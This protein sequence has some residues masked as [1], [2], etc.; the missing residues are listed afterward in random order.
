MCR[1]SIRKTQRLTKLVYTFRACYGRFSPRTR[2]FRCWSVAV[3]DRRF[4]TRS[5]HE[6]TCKHIT[7]YGRRFER[8]SKF[9][10]YLRQFDKSYRVFFPVGKSPSTVSAGEQTRRLLIDD[11]CD[12]GKFIDRINRQVV[13]PVSAV[14]Q[15][16]RR[17]R[18]TLV[19][20]LC[21]RFRQRMADS[22]HRSI[23][24]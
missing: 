23:R 1:I 4:A 21:V 14:S 5:G 17:R 22:T 16:D 6:N 7:L 20:V 10:K 13:L 9:R 11:R 18:R 3:T 2:S 19:R 24:R 12:F 8:G 15:N